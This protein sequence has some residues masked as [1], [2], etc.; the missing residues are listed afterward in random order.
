M[1]RPAGPPPDRRSLKEAALTHIARFAATEQG[2]TRVLERRIIRWSHRALED[3]SDSASVSETV[4]A[5]LPL[6]GETARELVAA[7]GVDDHAFARARAAR[8]AR[9][10]HSRRA[11]E[12]GLAAKGIPTATATAALKEA[13]GDDPAETDLASA[14]IF[15]RRKRLGPFA[16]APDNRSDESSPE[17][18]LRL[19][20]LRLYGIFARAGFPRD[21]V[22]RILDMD[23]MEAEDRIL[24]FKA[25]L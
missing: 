18:E 1:S 25:S 15:A 2:L 11:V 21:V 23:P 19:D 17:D 16:R 8:M 12:A 3:G 7:G 24:T 5:L 9:G 4:R 22:R 20:E 6:A 13:L 14:L 10:G